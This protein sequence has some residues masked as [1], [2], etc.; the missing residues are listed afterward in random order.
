MVHGFKA[1]YRTLPILFDIH[2]S[3]I[4]GIWV[5]NLYA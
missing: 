4:D 5:V 1:R 2:P 3:K